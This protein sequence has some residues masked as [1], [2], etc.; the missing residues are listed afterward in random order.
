MHR[1]VQLDGGRV[2]HFL[3]IIEAATNNLTI[4][5][6]RNGKFRMVQRKGSYAPPSFQDNVHPP[7]GRSQVSMALKAET[8]VNA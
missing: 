4:F 5:S 2:A 7:G 3:P 1:V 8:V 6:H